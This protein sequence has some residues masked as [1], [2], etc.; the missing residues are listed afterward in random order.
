MFYP[1]LIFFILALILLG[2]PTYLRFRLFRAPLHKSS[3]QVLSKQSKQVGYSRRRLT[4]QN[5]CSEPA[6]YQVAPLG[7]IHRMVFLYYASFRLENG[8][9]RTLQLPR[10]A[11]QKL[12]EGAAVE[13]TF[14]RNVVRSCQS[15]AFSYAA[16][17]RGRA[18]LYTEL[19][20]TLLVLF[21]FCGAMWVSG[22][23]QSAWNK[24]MTSGITITSCSHS[25]WET[26]SGE[27]G[28]PSLAQGQALALSYYKEAPLALSVDALLPQEAVAPFLQE[29]QEKLPRHGQ[30]DAQ[31]P[32]DYFFAYDLPPSIANAAPQSQIKVFLLSDGNAKVQ[33]LEAYPSKKILRLFQREAGYTLF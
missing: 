4:F 8:E 29:A 19:A 5:C 3:A 13:L 16:P 9:E 26:L 28:L 30:E 2:Y 15:P 21:L 18:S 6:Y 31:Q 14:Q 20:F 17:L 11:F 23:K 32:S 33:I 22:Q 12:E 27:L 24:D 1:F 10:E 7:S 25:S